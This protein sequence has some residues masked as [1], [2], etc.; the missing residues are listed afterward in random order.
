MNL[1]ARKIHQATHT[2]LAGA[3]Q[4]S[5]VPVSA[6]RRLAR[7]SGSAGAQLEYC[8][9]CGASIPATH[10]HVFDRT[11][12]GVKCACQA[13]ALLFAREGAGGGTF[14]IIPTRVRRLSDFQLTDEQWDDLRI[15]VDMAFFIREGESGRPIASYPG[16]AGVTTSLLELDQWNA[17]ASANPVLGTL[18]SDV[19][20]LLVNRVSSAREYYLVPIDRCYELAGRIRRT[21]RGLSGGAE[22]WQA[23]AAFFAELRIRAEVEDMG[24]DV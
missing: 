10:R 16:A 1:S 11:G 12:R 3:S 24:G 21:W 22:T 5:R 7:G 8:E 19:E 17:L 4:R 13:C 15:P 6:L 18:V 9:L 2:G 14:V 20:A 23:I